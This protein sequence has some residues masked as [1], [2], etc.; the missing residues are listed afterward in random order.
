MKAHSP[1]MEVVPVADY[2][3]AVLLCP[4]EEDDNDGFTSS[5]PLL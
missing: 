1:L 5:A 3:L 4:Q 2:A